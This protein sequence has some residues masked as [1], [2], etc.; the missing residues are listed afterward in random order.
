MRGLLQP[1]EARSVAEVLKAEGLPVVA[2]LDDVQGNT[3]TAGLWLAGH[4]TGRRLI[5]SAAVQH[6]KGSLL[7][8]PFSGSTR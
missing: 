4:R 3:W 7:Q 1:V 8:I 5:V 6:R 2:A